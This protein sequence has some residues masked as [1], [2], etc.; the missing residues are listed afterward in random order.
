M[1]SSNTIKHV[2]IIPDGNR[3]WAKSLGKPSVY[4]HEAGFSRFK[5]LTAYAKNK[6]IPFLTIWAFSTEN[7]NRNKEEV[8]GLMT[9]IKRALVEINKEAHEGKF[10]FV[11]IGRKDRLSEDIAKLIEKTEEETKSYEKFCLCV[12]IDYGG[13]DE[14]LRAERK[15]MESK[16]KD[17]HIVDFLDTTLAGIPSPDLIIRTSGEK[18]ISG[19]MPVQSTYSELVFE[20]KMFP[21]FTEEVFQSALDEYEKRT[22]RYGK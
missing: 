13:E 14:V 15:L 7:W 20:E 19:F 6:G 21:D 9:I 5:E 16:N 1:S 3:R 12:A 11:H 22:R 8:K 10:R 18:R 17:K 4:G 2:A